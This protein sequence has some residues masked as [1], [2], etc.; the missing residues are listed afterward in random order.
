MQ[1]DATRTPW[2]RSC[3]NRSTSHMLRY[4]AKELFNSMILSLIIRSPDALLYGCSA[5]PRPAVRESQW[6]GSAEK[7]AMVGGE[8]HCIRLHGAY[9]LVRDIGREA[10]VPA[11]RYCLPGIDCHRCSR[12]GIALVAII[13]SGSPSPADVPYYRNPSARIE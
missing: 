13:A 1:P 5:A 4:A 12:P 9:A 8:S 7:E 3:V 2:R 11:N 6:T 10:A